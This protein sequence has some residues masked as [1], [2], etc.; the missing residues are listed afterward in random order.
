MMRRTVSRKVTF[1]A[2][3][4]IRIIIE[5]QMTDMRP[6]PA[7]TRCAQF[8]VRSVASIQALRAY[9]IWRKTIRTVSLTCHG[10][11]EDAV[12]NTSKKV[13][14]NAPMFRLYQRRLGLH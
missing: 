8:E 7:V 12:V 14:K 9:D 10:T 5:F 1:G 2:N 6:S 4:L 13:K 11:I 3:A